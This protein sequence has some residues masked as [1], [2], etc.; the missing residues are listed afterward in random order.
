[1]KIKEMRVGETGKITR[2]S[3]KDKMYRNKL[4]QMGLTKG[5]EFKVLRKAP[6]G[7]PLEIETRG[8]KLT[9]RKAEADMLEVETV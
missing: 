6:M 2:F 9:L 4:L 5:T 8:F 7:D 1:M 3:G